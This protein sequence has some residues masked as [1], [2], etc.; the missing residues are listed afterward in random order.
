MS[1]IVALIPARSGSVRVKHKN[2][3]QFDGIP[4]LGLAVRQA[5]LAENVDEVY[6]S[7]DSPIYAEVAKNYGAVVP[8]LRPEEISGSDATDYDVFIHFLNWYENEF[9]ELPEMIV[10]VRPT[11]PVRQS[12]SIGKAV[13]FMIDHPEFDSLRSVSIPHQSPYKMWNMSERFKLSPILLT[14]IEEGFDKPTQSLP[15]VYSQ[16]GIVDIVRP[17]TLLKYHSMAGKNI[18]GFVDHPGTWDIDTVNDLKNAEKLYRSKEHYLLLKKPQALGG[19]LAIIQGRLTESDI[20]QKF[21]DDDWRKEFDLARKA[22]Y[23]SIEWIRDSSPNNNNPIWQEYFD[24]SEILSVSILSGV[25]VRSICDD[26]VQTCDWETLSLEQFGLLTE[27]IIRASK[28]GVKT[29]VYPL[30]CDA[31]ITSASKLMAFK[32]HIGVLSNVAATQGIKIALEMSLPVKDMIEFFEEIQYSNVGICLDTGNLYASGVSSMDILSCPQ[33]VNKI[34]HVHIKDRDS[35]FNNVVLGE[36]NVNF[37][38]ILTH[39]VVN[40]YIGMVVTETSR[41]ENPYDIAIKN[42]KFLCDIIS[43]F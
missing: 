8:F 19:N 7:T 42:K 6:I 36:G 40:G 37:N 5:L 28:L 18:A 43:K 11:A 17:E 25:S 2:L 1:K 29:I 12:S 23:S 14:D 31:E 21:P 9:N 38:S 30:F 20:L 41:G 39:L 32:K 13:C 3:R 10:Q 33:L 27:L 22:G 26:Y 16:D 24:V 4:L 34:W 35:D 15:C